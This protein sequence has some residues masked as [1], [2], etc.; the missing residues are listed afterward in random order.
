[1]RLSA[2]W[3]PHYSWSLAPWAYTSRGG[4]ETTTLFM[5]YMHG[6]HA[7]E[8][9]SG[10]ARPGCLVVRGAPSWRCYIFTKS[11]YSRLHT[12]AQQSWL[13][14]ARRGR[15]RRSLCDFAGAEADFRAIL[16]VK[17]THAAAEKELDSA[18]R[19]LQA[20]EAARLGRFPSCSLAFACRVTPQ[21]YFPGF[22]K[23]AWSSQ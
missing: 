15:I 10:W 3:P 12:G 7:D 6:G 19:G 16:A 20:L 9:S 5:L 1:M 23:D 17:P 8:E 14:A 18:T 2:T 13:L 21:P 11:A 4:I 22:S